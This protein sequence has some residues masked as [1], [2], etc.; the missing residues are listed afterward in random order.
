MLP[1]T[2]ETTQDARQTLLGYLEGGQTGCLT[3][4]SERGLVSVYVMLGEVLAAHTEHDAE[5][6]ISLLRNGVD[7]PSEALDALAV[8]VAGGTSLAEAL[9]DA[10]PDARVLELLF[11]RFRDNLFHFLV[12]G[13]AIEF[14]AMDAVFTDN[15]QVGHDSRE[16]IDELWT[17][18]RR[19]AGLLGD[20]SLTL[21]PG[22]LA[23]RGPEQAS[24]RALCGAS[25]SIGTLLALSPW[26]SAR[27]LERVQDMI[28]DGV[29]VLRTPPPE[30]EALPDDEPPTEE[31]AIT[32]QMWGDTE[33][34][35][36]MAAFQD[37]DTNRVGGDFTTERTLLDRVELE[38]A[39]SA[40]P[41]PSLAA[42]TETV[43]EMEDAENAGKDALVGVVSLNFSG[44]KLHDEEAQRKIDVVNEV[45]ATVCAAIEAVEGPGS[46]QARV[47][48]LVEGS[49]GALVPL[50]KHVEVGPDGRLA[51]QTVLKNLHKRPA[52]EHR[53]LLQRGLA[54]LVDRALSLANE[55][56]DDE[57][58]EAMLEKIAGYQQRLGI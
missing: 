7:V 16:L 18:R 11:E 38:G 23:P 15:I 33:P 44:P 40:Q 41:R 30:E 4:H 43:I 57:A 5:R 35:P 51:V 1:R 3:G 32:E 36:E 58:L 10:V 48:V 39:A 27:T 8:A 25:L 45:L 52:T 50:F 54:D 49:T 28:E 55:S 9:F 53:R 13:G 2:G 31:A 19:V 46:G 42:S 24:L 26:E 21:A 17:V 47:Q 56:L 37:Y 14:T 29:L 20:E 12:G 22:S 34:D 6:M